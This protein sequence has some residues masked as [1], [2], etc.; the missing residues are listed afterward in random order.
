MSFA[1]FHNLAYCQPDDV[2]FL[3]AKPVA[4]REV[5][6]GACRTH[7][8]PDMGQSVIDPVEA[9][10]TL[11]S[12]TVYTGLDDK[13]LNFFSGE[14]ASINS[15]VGFAQKY[16]AAFI[17]LVVALLTLLHFS[18]LLWSKVRPTLFSPVSTLLAIFVALFALVRKAERAASLS[19]EVVRGC[20]KSLM[21]TKTS[22]G[23]H[24]LI[25]IRPTLNCKET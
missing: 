9:S 15:L 14:I 3:G 25:N 24:S 20:I 10:W 19:M 21:A 22:A 18:L 7:V 8:T 12:S 5:T 17:S 16:R 23:H 13:R 4:A 11:G 2:H 1:R 6:W